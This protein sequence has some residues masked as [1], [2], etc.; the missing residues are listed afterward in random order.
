MLFWWYFWKLWAE[1]PSPT[2]KRR[3]VAK[4]ICFQSYVRDKKNVDPRS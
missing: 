4:V 2:L 1:S 3:P